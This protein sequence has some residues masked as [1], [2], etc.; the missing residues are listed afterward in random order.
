M[1][2]EVYLPDDRVTPV[3]EALYL[4]YPTLSLQ[5]SEFLTV[6]HEPPFSGQ[7]PD[8]EVGTTENVVLQFLISTPH[9]RR[10]I[11]KNE[12]QRHVTV[13][14][15]WE[16][17]WEEA[18]SEYRNGHYVAGDR[19]DPLLVIFDGLAYKHVADLIS[20]SQLMN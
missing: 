7:M 10:H 16:R 4:K 2:N 13:G 5:G 17:G 19:K 18:E 14:T 15:L 3:Q 11:Y 12:G 20:L 8:G 9:P 6:R 1:S